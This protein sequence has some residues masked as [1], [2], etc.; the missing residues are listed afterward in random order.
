M[1]VALFSFSICPPNPLLL[2]VQNIADALNP[3]HTFFI[4]Q[5]RCPALWL[6]ANFRLVVGCTDLRVSG[7]SPVDSP[8]LNIYISLLEIQ[9]GWTWLDLASLPFCLLFPKLQF[10]VHFATI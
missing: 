1:A 6:L 7:L 4:A 5:Y 10:F 2:L 8:R 9:K 3:S